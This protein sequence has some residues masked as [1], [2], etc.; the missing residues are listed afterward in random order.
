MGQR[1]AGYLLQADFSVSS[2]GDILGCSHSSLAPGLMR[3]G[4]EEAAVMY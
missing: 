3:R 2:S 4:E 1:K